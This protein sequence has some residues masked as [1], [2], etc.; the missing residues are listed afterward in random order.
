MRNAHDIAIEIEHML[1]K[2]FGFEE[3][4]RGTI[5]D[6][7]KI[8]SY[9]FYDLLYLLLYRKSNKEWFGFV[10]KIFEYK[11]V[12]MNQIPEYEKIFEEFKSL[13]T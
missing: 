13:L 6:A 7:D 1:R 2:E 3:R 12:N 10:D 11:G 5:F 9:M 4:P 8:E